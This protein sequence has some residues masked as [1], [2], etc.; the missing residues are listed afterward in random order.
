MSVPKLEIGYWKIRGLAAPLRMLLNYAEVDFVDTQMVGTTPEAKR[1]VW[2]E[3]R[4]PELLKKNPLV[5]LPFVVDG[6][7]VI[8]QSNQCLLYVARKYGLAG[9]P[10]TVDAVEQ[11]LLEVFDLRNATVSVAY[12]QEPREKF[13]EI[14][15][16]HFSGTVKTSLDKLE[17][18]FVFY[19]KTFACT[20][21]PSVCDFHL[22]EMLDQ[23]EMMKDVVGV[24]SPLSTRPKLAAFYKAFRE[25]PQL[26]KY[27]ASEA[28]KLPVNN[29]YAQFK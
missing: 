17:S 10:E 21:T 12:C 15:S 20:D 29:I 3:G 7:T 19:G 23:H 9:T 14:M 4:K 22:W 25:L 24:E 13:L 18:C 6:E 27:F 2:F 1:E 11:I 5:S 28:Y 16:A 8:T 26:Q